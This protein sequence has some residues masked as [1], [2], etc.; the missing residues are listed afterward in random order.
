MRKKN[1]TLSKDFRSVLRFRLI[2]IASLFILYGAT[3]GARLFFLQ[4]INHEALAAQS[5]KQYAATTKI[6]YGRGT[7]LD[8]N[9]NELAMN[10]EV[11]SVYITPSKV[12][13]KQHT[14]RTLASHLQLDQKKVYNKISSKKHFVWIKRK[15]DLKASEKLRRLDLPGV[16]FISEQKRFYPKRELAANVTGFVGLDNQGLS[17]VEHHYQST[18]KGT[19]VRRVIEKDARGRNIGAIGQSGKSKTKSRDVVLTLDEVIQFITERHLKEQIEKYQAEAGTAIVMEPYT[20]E[21]LALANFPHFNPNKYLAYPPQKWKN[22]AI[23]SSFEPGSIFKPIAAAAALDSGAAKPND[24]FFCENG[25]IHIGR[26]PIGEASNHRFGWLSLQNII[27]KSSNIGA[28]KIA[29]KI[30]NQSFYNY[31]RKFGFGDKTGIDLPGE[32]PGQLK[33]VSQWSDLSLAS[34]SFGHEIAVTPIQMVAALSAIANGGNLM[35]PRITKAV[36]KNG[37]VVETYTPKGV[38]RVISEKTSRQM[39][40]IL[41]KTVKTGT[42]TPAALT[43]FEAAGKTGTA[44]KY[45]KVSGAYSKKDYL[46][47]FVGFVPADA[48]KLVVLVMIDSPRKAYWGGE[49]AGPVFRKISKEVLRYLNVPAKDERVYFLSRA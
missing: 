41:K 13:D 48:P 27:V 8:R 25:K 7:I 43:G 16:G 31:I 38:R 29:Q 15:C 42:G 21:I 46:S 22:P 3:L 47:S 1:Q 17:G 5:E 32:S 49:V 33:H 28:I 34:I 30:G 37:K 36:L 10:V 18:L 40:E 6:V 26:V 44:Q 11:E 14:A 2:L 4:I 23:S 12:V 39:I 35:L 19:T 24:L 9:Q 20:G 45:D